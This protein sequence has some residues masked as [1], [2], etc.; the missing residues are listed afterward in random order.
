MYD[1]LCATFCS[2]CNIQVISIDYR[3]APENKFPIPPLDCIAAYNMLYDNAQQYNIDVHQLAIG[4]DSA[5]GNLSTVVTSNAIKSNKCPKFQLLIYP[6]VKDAESPSFELFKEGFLLETDDKINAQLLFEDIISD[7]ENGP[8]LKEELEYI[9][10]WMA[11]KDR[12]LGQSLLAQAE[13]K[14][15]KEQQGQS[16]LGNMLMAGMAMS[17]MKLSQDIGEVSDQVENISEGFGFEG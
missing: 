15:P 13:A 1:Y 8:L 5:G 3:L 11:F 10:K 6:V 16:P 12:E 17:T 14:K 4:G 7:S 2:K 9:K